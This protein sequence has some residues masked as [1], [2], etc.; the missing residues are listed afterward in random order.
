M[1]TTVEV[2]D[3]L[4][5]AAKKKAAEL[6]KPLRYLIELGLKELLGVK[7]PKHQKRRKKG[8]KIKWIT[9]PGGLPDVDVADRE[10]MHEWLRAQHGN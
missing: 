9:V 6:R 2:D 3:D 8:K 5:I 7:P 10:N 1:R 4:L